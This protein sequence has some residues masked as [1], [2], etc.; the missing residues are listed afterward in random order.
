MLHP[1]SIVLAAALAAVVAPARATAHGP[2]CA[3]SLGPARDAAHA[4]ATGALTP[5]P[6]LLAGVRELD[7]RQARGSG[8]VSFTFDDGPLA[9]STPRVLDVLARY[10]VPATFFVVGWHLTGPRGAANAEV[11][12]RAQRE[13]HVIG[14]HTFHHE[15]LETASRREAWD[16][17]SR[18][19]TILTAATG[20]APVLFRAP[21]GKLSRDALRLLGD[22]DLTV[23][24]WSIDGHEFG[25]ASPESL[26]DTILAALFA[27][28]GGVVILHDTHPLAVAALPLILSGLERENCRRVA[29]GQRPIV[30]VPLALLPGA[31]GD[32]PER[33]AAIAAARQRVTASCQQPKP[34]RRKR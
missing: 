15:R 25:Q 31:G 7:G 1:R 12:G 14:N 33:D 16:T 17:V 5:R 34:S 20:E 9:A 22:L 21:Y 24:G 32:G 10:G 18:N 3:R 27:E 4:L 13:G 8:L 26:R 11:L 30:A 19:Q 29:A 6:R 23:V 28:D 2:A